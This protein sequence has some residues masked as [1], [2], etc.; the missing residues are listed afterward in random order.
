MDDEVVE[1]INA[2]VRQLEEKWNLGVVVA[3]FGVVTSILEA[4]AEFAFDQ[5]GKISKAT[6]SQ[7][8][9]KVGLAT[10][11][12]LCLL[13][14]ESAITRWFGLREKIVWLIQ[15]GVA[16]VI[17]GCFTWW[18][19]WVMEDGAYQTIDGG[20]LVAAA[21]SIAML[22]GIGLVIAIKTDLLLLMILADHGEDKQVPNRE[23]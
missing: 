16:L 17:T 21:I 22:F 7:T 1:D 6:L 4:A 2:L 15:G 23:A 11:T 3:L 19:A 8:S 14:K 18:A 5:Q 20:L 13:W 10:L 9:I 12:I